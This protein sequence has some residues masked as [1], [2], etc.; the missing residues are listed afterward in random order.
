VHRFD[1]KP[2]F[3]QSLGLEDE[4]AAIAIRDQFSSEIRTYSSGSSF[5]PGN[6]GPEGAIHPTAH[7]LLIQHFSHDLV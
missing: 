5:D 1:G 2:V 3:R 4:Q 6:V 7:V